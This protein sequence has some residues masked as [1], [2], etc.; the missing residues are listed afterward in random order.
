MREGYCNHPVCLS[1]CLSVGVSVCLSLG[2]C[3]RVTVIILCVC[4]CVC[5]SVC[6][7]V[8]ALELTYDVCAT[9]LAYQCN[10]RCTQMVLN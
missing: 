4:L 10:L 2:A 1:V 9:K 5:L 6:L 7:S 3:A 8:T